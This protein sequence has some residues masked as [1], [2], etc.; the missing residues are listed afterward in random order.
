M[1]YELVIRRLAEQDLLEVIE[2]YEEKSQGL[3]Y[4]FYEEALRVLQR[5]RENPRQYARSEISRYRRATLD[6]FPVCIYFTV[7]QK[8]IV[9]IAFHDGRR[10]PLRWQDRA[11]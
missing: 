2:F 7:I 10:N 11:E 8:R 3:G 6:V 4:R 9:V 5:M 1:M